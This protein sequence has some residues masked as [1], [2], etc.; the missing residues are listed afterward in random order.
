VLG[1]LRDATFEE[2]DV[3]V[4]LSSRAARNIVKHRQGPD[5][6][7]GTGDDDRIDTLGELDA[8]AYV[9]PTVLAHLVDYAYELEAVPSSDPFDDSFCMWDDPLAPEQFRSWFAPGAMTAAV[10]VKQ[11]HVDL[12]ARTCTSSGDC[13]AWTRNDGYED[14]FRYAFDGD[15]IHIPISTQGADV[16]A[17]AKVKTTAY[18]SSYFTLNAT[19]RPGSWVEAIKAECWLAPDLDDPSVLEPSCNLYT[20]ISNFELASDAAPGTVQPADLHVGAHCTRVAYH[21]SQTRT[22]ETV[23]R[24]F[25][26]SARY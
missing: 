7:D 5:G 16:T 10:P 4:A 9:G 2:L 8:I 13:P 15:P 20:E 22:N 12:W 23:E 21:E 17:T 1:L 26:W 11:S 25:V 19:L 24:I 6:V 18:E 14:A 3:D